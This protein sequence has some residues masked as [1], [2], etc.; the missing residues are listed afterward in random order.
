[1]A[2]SSLAL[3]LSSMILIGR[4]STLP[5]ADLRPRAPLPL[6]LPPPALAT[7]SFPAFLSAPLPSESSLCARAL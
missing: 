4:E 6:P 7:A 1:M 3:L 5:A 2:L